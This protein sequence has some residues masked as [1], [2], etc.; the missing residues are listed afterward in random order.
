V[1]AD[2]GSRGAA[3]VLLIIGGVMLTLGVAAGARG[4]TL[5]SGPTIHEVTV[6]YARPASE[7]ELAADVTVQPVSI[8]RGAT[9]GELAARYGLP[10]SRIRRA[11]LEHYDL[12]RIRSDREI[13]LS[14]MDGDPMPVELRY[15]LDEDRTLVVRRLG[16]DWVPEL[17]VVEYTSAIG[18]RA[19]EITRSLWEDGLAAGL[20]PGDLARLAVIFQYELDFNTELRAGA[21]LAVVAEVMSADERPDRLGEIHAVRLS[22]GA[23]TWT[24]IRHELPSG[25]QGWYQPGGTS[26]RKPFLRS[27]LA[28]SRVTS[29]F[30]PRR[31]HPVL[32]RRRPHNGTDF[33]A[34]T[35]TE[36]RA[37][38]EGRVVQARWSGGHGRFVK[39][40][41]DGGYETSYSHL[42]R[43]DVKRGQRVRQGKVIGLVGSTGLA[44]GPHLHFQMW[45]NGSFV[46]PMK[47]DLPNQSPLPSTE[48]GSFRKSVE[49]WVPMLDNAGRDGSAADPG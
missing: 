5:L 25:E 28:F 32:K 41:H 43:I 46:D 49:R 2:L 1:L 36:V 16:E 23:R 3:V 12:A 42:S 15:A 19:F 17:Q 47:I 45:R 39:I 11:A 44:T 37:V 21:S 38:A 22:N 30:N 20:R 40:E 9:F 24:A 27:P 10:A 31:Y 18:T 7:P 6:P 34:S 29:G 8:G 26:L 13:V 4:A 35:G 33:G 48:L 14:W